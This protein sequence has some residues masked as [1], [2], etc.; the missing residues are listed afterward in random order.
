MDISAAVVTAKKAIDGVKQVAGTT[1]ARMTAAARDEPTIFDRL[2]RD[3]D[4]FRKLMKQLA[5]T[6][7]RGVKQRRRL[8]DMLRRTVTAHARAE[9]AVLYA[10]LKDVKATRPEVFE[11]HEE[12]HLAD[13]IFA[14]MAR[15]S[16]GDE[17]WTAKAAV[18]RESLRHHIDEEE[19]ELFVA[20][21]KVLPPD[22][23]VALGRAFAADKAR[24]L[25]KTARSRGG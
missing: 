12:H 20:G 18:L 11:G 3:H 25:A 22:T 5:A 6:T 10:A 13:L 16:P 23:A 14:E 17:R 4:D 21:R 8:F 1:L 7:S 9:E 2:K 15:L 19:R 24:R